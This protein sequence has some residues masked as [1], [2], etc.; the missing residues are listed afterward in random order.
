M[1]AAR[2]DNHAVWI[3]GLVFDFLALGI[4]EGR[5]YRGAPAVACVGA[6]PNSAWFMVARLGI[7]LFS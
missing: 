1:N 5:N 3:L 6:I 4:V 2:D 7:D